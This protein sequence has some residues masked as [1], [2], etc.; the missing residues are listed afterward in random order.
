MTNSFLTPLWK[1]YWT[2]LQ[3][4]LDLV[5]QEEESCNIVGEAHDWLNLATSLRLREEPFEI[6]SRTKDVAID[7][8]VVRYLTE[9]LRL[10]NLAEDLHRLSIIAGTS[11]EPL[12]GS[13]AAL[14]QRLVNQPITSPATTAAEGRVVLTSHPTESTRRT[15]L[16]HMKKL[17]LLLQQP[18]SISN[19]LEIREAL[20]AIWR[21]PSQR[22]T[23]PTVADE[24]ELGLYYIR[25]SLFD[26]LPQ[27]TSEIE[28]LVSP[29]HLP[30]VDWKIESWIGGDRDGHPYVDA[31][32]T[33]WTL[34]RHREV[35]RELYSERLSRLEHVL[36]SHTR[37]LHHQDRIRDWLETQS[38]QM[39]DAYAKLK[40]RYPQE[41]L[42]QVV[43][44]INER[45][46]QE[47]YRDTQSLY[48][49]IVLLEEAWS[50]HVNRR[51]P[52][53]SLLSR[54]VKTFGT[55]LASLDI[56]QHSRVHHEALVEIFGESYER[57]T[58]SEKLAILNQAF[59]NPPAFH[60][61][62][63]SSLELQ[64]T[65]RVIAEAQ[66]LSGPDSV[67]HYLISMV[68]GASDL[69]GVLLLLRIL[70]PEVVVD[71]IPVIETLNDLERCPKIMAEAYQI[72]AWR[73]HVHQR[74]DYLEVM[75]GYSDSTKD[76]GML[77]ASWAIFQ[78]AD[79][80]SRWAQHQGIRLGFFHGRGGA[81]GR[82]GGPTSYAIMG[83]P[84][85]S[86]RHRFRVTQQ[87]EVLSQKF[88]LPDLAHRSL[89]LMTTAHVEALLYP[90]SDPGPKVWTLFNQLA[91]RAL[92]QYRSLIDARNFW[93]YFL[94][95]TPIREM[96]A[97]NWGSR[98]S[99][100][101]KFD[102]GDLRAI[103]WVFSWTQNRTLLP[104]WYGAGTALSSLPDS[105]AQLQE[106]YR[107]WPFWHT[108]VHNME[109]AL[110]KADLHVAEAYQNLTTPSLKALFWPAIQEEYLRL[111]EAVLRITGHQELLDDQ[112]T[113]KEVIAW[114]NPMV[115]PLNYLQ[116]ETL[117]AYRSTGNEDYLPILAQTMEGIALG[118]RNTG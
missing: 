19:D 77:T 45:L 115:D 36:T 118:L 33:Q 82:G 74:G 103:P 71:I 56:R 37:Y 27:V 29:Q 34:N 96:A 73:N 60:P 12:R 58:E 113:L 59:D 44:L 79:S 40:D 90:S 54:Q 11:S 39:P 78:A 76:A 66:Q 26:M 104:G 17:G 50:P 114:R 116:I 23:R 64:S 7:G 38:L 55:H 61:E 70:V 65:F 94:D 47:H 109:L 9:R 18:R 62:S 67:S 28:S 24:V 107:V 15:I 43:G 117:D 93:E 30:A 57:A 81:L 6:H 48:D 86:L 51:P 111:K 31:Q 91:H 53:L 46:R 100:R 97:L 80:L 101:E 89:E 2:Q 52:L 110:V 87:G 25:E 112:I 102:W 21:T 13:V 5:V 99:W 85:A 3:P 108:L 63:A 41:P 84:Y 83:Q 1:S 22:T 8:S 20:R 106:L 32:V 42:R 95:V 105:Y 98:P 68:H 10:Q 69:V 35:A 16:Q 49:D 92:I 14:R 88:L 4:L 75:L 72:P